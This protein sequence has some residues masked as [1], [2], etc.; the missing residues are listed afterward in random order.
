MS[1]YEQNLI[2]RSKIIRAIRDFFHE[3]NFSEI[4][5]P[6]MIKAPAPEEY[7]EAV[8]AHKTQFL[9]TS[10]ELQMKKLLCN[11]STYFEKIFQIGSCFRA[12]ENGR[13]HLEEFTMLEWYQVGADYNALMIFI[14]KL[15]VFI[16]KKV[17]NKTIISYQGREIDLLSNWQKI[18]VKDAFLKFTQSDVNS[19]LENNHFD[20]LMVDKIEPQLGFDS[21]AILYDYP[22]CCASLSRLKRVDQ[23]VAERFEMYIA[24][25]ELA[26]AYSELTD[27][28][29]QFVR[30]KDALKFRAEQG[31]NEYPQAEEF[32]NALKLQEMPEC[33]GCALGID[34][35]VMI[36]TDETDINNVVHLE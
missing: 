27:Y 20:L 7:I 11:S 8:T 16:G 34:R 15:L 31:M 33:A 29:E 6:V 4:E 24:G 30:F 28:N 23:S 3:N 5:T 2:I 32:L 36:F 25:L 18:S 22:A 35:L 9:R 13:R 17:F 10:P 12:D 1:K 21:P 19:A 14:K 26:N